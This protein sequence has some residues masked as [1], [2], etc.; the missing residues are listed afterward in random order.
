MGAVLDYLDEW[1]TVVL[2]ALGP[3]ST[4][5]LQARVDQARAHVIRDTAHDYDLARGEVFTL[6]IIN[7]SYDDDL[8]AILTDLAQDR[9]LAA[10]IGRM[11][12]AQ[13]ALA[14]R[15]IRLADFHD[16]GQT[17]GDLLRGGGNAV[18]GIVGSIP[19]ARD[20][21]AMEYLSRRQDLPAPY[22]AA[23]DQID[24]AQMTQA[25]T[26]GNVALATTLGG[27]DQ[28]TFGAVSMI[29]GVGGAAVGL[30]RGAVDLGRGNLEEGAQEI[31]PALLLVA[32]A[33]GLRLALRPGAAAGATTLEGRLALLA[34]E[35][36]AA[37]RP[38]R[39]ELGDAQ[40][41]RA[42]QIIRADSRA[43]FLVQ[44]YGER[45]VQAL[46]AADGD[47]AAARTALATTPAAPLPAATVAITTPPTTPAAGTTATPQPTGAGTLATPAVAAPAV[48][49]T[50][51]GTGSLLGA[52]SGPGVASGE[53]LA[54]RLRA[55]GV[56]GPGI[57][58]PLVADLNAQTAMA[59]EDKAV[60][61]TSACNA[62]GRT[63]G[64]GPVVRMPDGSFI[65]TPRQPALG[66]PVLIVTR[67]GAVLRGNADVVLTPD[68]RAYQV[69]NVV[70]R[71]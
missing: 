63:F 55:E 26:P 46:L 10:T 47:V 21:T 24:N 60:A 34:E 8:R 19:L 32:T 6:S 4:T 54:E 42:A 57:L 56:R 25:M 71:Q 36:Q 52:E 7:K 27:L 9:R 40:I 33:I 44:Q 53:A 65:V 29:R 13:A 11:P 43:A 22:V 17:A 62:Q 12:S 70:P 58:R 64:A 3:L 18:S 23:L 37:L 14:Q 45:G 39:A 59:A 48:A 28:A 16:R 15:G 61:A 5:A 68:L 1:Q 50:E 69:S 41:L 66:A 38:L 20:T 67:E 51:M 49:A 30:V 31:F 2:G 35:S